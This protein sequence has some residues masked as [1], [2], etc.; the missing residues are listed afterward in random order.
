MWIIYGLAIIGGIVILCMIGA[1]IYVAI[2]G[3]VGR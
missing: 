1:A 3:G 2:N